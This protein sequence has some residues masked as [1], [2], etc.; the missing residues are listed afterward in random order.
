[1]DP[2]ARRALLFDF[3]GSLLTD[4]QREAYDLHYQQDYSYAEVAELLGVSRAGAADLVRRA[5]RTLASLEAAVGA[6][7]R[8]LRE[9]ERVEALKRVLLAGDTVA[10]L[11]I[12]ESWQR[13][14]GQDVV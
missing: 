6:V 10:A 7:A 8:H 11:Q 1:M 12:L 5:E 14:R 4:R 9:G 2:L 13:E 3:Y